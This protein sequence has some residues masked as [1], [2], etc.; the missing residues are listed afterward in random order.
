MELEDCSNGG[1]WAKPVNYS[2]ERGLWYVRRKDRRP[3][4]SVSAIRFAVGSWQSRPIGK[5]WNLASTTLQI[6]L[7]IDL[8]ESEEAWTFAGMSAADVWQ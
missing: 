5:P 2:E 4:T 7:R 3:L 6:V 8:C 1:V